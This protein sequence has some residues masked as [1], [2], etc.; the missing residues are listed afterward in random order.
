M[1]G[2]ASTTSVRSWSC[3][4]TSI[5][6]ARRTSCRFTERRTS[7]NEMATKKTTTG[8]APDKRPRRAA[9]TKSKKKPAAVAEEAV[10]PGTTSLVIVESPAKAKTIGKYL[11][12]GYR[13]KA[14]VGHILD[15]P[16]KKLGIDVDKD[17]APVYETIPG[18]EKTVADLKE[19]A[20][21]SR[22]IFIATDPDRE[23]EA[24]AW[25]VAEQIRPKRVRGAAAVASPPIRR[26]L[27]HEITKYAIRAAMD[28]AGV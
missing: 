16:R 8:A 19:A 13:V 9:S 12:R 23:G 5:P 22:E 1:D 4:D 26:V 3:P 11:G 7:P 10:A 17:F 28:N 27:F 14:T 25:H 2:S 20:S 24:I 18:K 21:G 6:A 15:L